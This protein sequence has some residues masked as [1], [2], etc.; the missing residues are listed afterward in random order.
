MRSPFFRSK[1]VFH[2]FFNSSVG[3]SLC[4]ILALIVE[5]LTLA[6]AELQLYVFAGK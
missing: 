1:S 2:S 6:N 5:L 4:G 3:I